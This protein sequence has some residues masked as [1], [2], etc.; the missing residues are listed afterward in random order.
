MKKG[1][2]LRFTMKKK[3]LMVVVAA[4]IVQT[5]I[6][7][8]PAQGQDSNENWSPDLLG[9]IAKSSESFQ[10][11]SWGANRDL[12]RIIRQAY[13]DLLRREPDEEELRYYRSRIIDNGWTERDVRDDLQRSQAYGRHGTQISRQQA[14]QIV[15]QAYHD[16]LGREPDSGAQGWVDKVLRDRWTEQDVVRA[17]RDSDEYRRG[18]Q[19]SRQQAEQIVRRAYRDVL[20]REPDS[21]AQGWVDKVLRD[22]WTEQDVVRALRDSDEYRSKHR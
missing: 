12:D 7:F 2:N 17:L 10:R 14:E 9:A 21:G 3:R 19:I 20:G 5:T 18:G 13:D 16:V 22:R 4:M 11:D 15:R 6:L 8:A 1:K